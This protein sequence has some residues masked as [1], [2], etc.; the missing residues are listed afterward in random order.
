MKI[1]ALEIA[2]R[3]GLRKNRVIL[4]PITPTQ[5]QAR[6]L[7]RVFLPVVQ[8]WENGTDRL[9]A[10]YSRAI[11]MTSDSIIDLEAIIRFLQDQVAVLIETEVRNGIFRWADNLAL[12]HFRRF[13][14][15]LKYATN[16]DF[17]TLIG[18][19][20]SQMTLEDFL[21]RNA[22]LIRDVSD[23]TRGKVADIV[24][25][26]LQLRTPARDVAKEITEATGLARKRAL[27]IASDQ[28]QKLSASLDRQR[29]LDVGITKFEWQHSSKVHYRPEH[30][31]RDGKT[32]DWDS[33]VARNDPPGFQPFCG[34]KAKGV[35]E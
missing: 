27:R 2:R 3:S 35:L 16:V 28:T 13:V 34:C 21:A 9:M 31:V 4:R 20:G 23:Q 10:E 25:R 12:W 29:Q 5:V 22:A 1:N 32:F 14:G 24:F 7:Y 33:E 15:N 26:N 19:A 30:L 17:Q 8:A 11:A 6:D 18:P